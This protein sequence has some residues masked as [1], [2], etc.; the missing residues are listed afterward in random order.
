M[1]ENRSIL[2]FTV[3]YETETELYTQIVRLYSLVCNVDLTEAEIPFVVYYLRYGYSKEIK[4]MIREDLGVKSNH[5]DVKNHSL[6][7]KGVLTLSEYGERRLELSENIM[8]LKDFI[9][10]NSSTKMIPI[11]FKSN[12]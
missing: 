3:N 5:I 10:K 9:E 4:K 1:E 7:K 6:K 11:V 12:G 2:S 8:V